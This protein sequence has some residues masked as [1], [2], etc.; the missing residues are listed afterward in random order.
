MVQLAAS[1]PDQPDAPTVVASY[2]SVSISWTEPNNGGV[3]IDN[4]DVY[5]DADGNQSD[6]FTIL[7]TT[8]NTFFN[9]NSGVVQGTVYKFKIVARNSINTSQ[10]SDPGS[11]LAASV[12]ASP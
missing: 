12:P 2:S 7:T 9:I 8:T 1:R 11:A 10:F 3:I 6:D 4:Y 5:Q